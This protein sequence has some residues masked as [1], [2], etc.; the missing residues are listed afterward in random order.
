MLTAFCKVDFTR[1]DKLLLLF[2]Y[3]TLLGAFDSF[4]IGLS[5]FTHEAAGLGA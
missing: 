4:K 2:D 3:K 1:N 5:T